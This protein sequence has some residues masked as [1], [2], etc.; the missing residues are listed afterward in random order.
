[1]DDT[2]KANKHFIRMYEQYFASN[3]NMPSGLAVQGE[4]Y[5]VGINENRH[6]IDGVAFC[7]FKLWDIV[8][9]TYLPWDTFIEFCHDNDILHAPVVFDGVL[10]EDMATLVYLTN[11]ANATEYGDGV[12]GE[13][14]VVQRADDA[15]VS[16]KLVS[17]LYKQEHGL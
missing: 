10:T 9:Q 4:V 2:S 3:Q 5:G 13:G 17:P 14:I 15:N 12:R 11:M 1:L 7:A 8:K 6:K 16:F